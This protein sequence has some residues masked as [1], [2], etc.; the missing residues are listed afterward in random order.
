MER[1]DFEAGTRRPRDIHRTGGVVLHP[2]AQIGVRVLVPVGVG[3]GQLM[4]DILGNGKRR[5]RQQDSD[6]ADREPVPQPVK[7]GRVTH[8]IRIE[9]HKPQ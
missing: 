2:L 3:G 9:Y 7:W 5:Q 1:D 8:G 6:E 4:M